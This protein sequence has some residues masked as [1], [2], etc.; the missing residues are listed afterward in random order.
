M[1]EYL[2]GAFVGY[3]LA[4]GTMVVWW[5]MCVVSSKSDKRGGYE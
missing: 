4:L 2:I 5:S 3:V 1:K